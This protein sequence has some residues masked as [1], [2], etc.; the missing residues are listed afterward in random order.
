MATTPMAGMAAPMAY[1]GLQSY[2]QVGGYGGYGA[3]GFGAPAGFG[4]T[5]GF[6]AMAYPAIDVAR[7]EEMKGARVNQIVEQAQALKAQVGH[8]QEHQLALI[9][10]RSDQEIQQ[11]TLQ[12]NARREQ[13][14]LQVSQST[15]QQA[16][17]LDQRQLQA[18][19]QIEQ[20]ALAVS[21]RAHLGFGMAHAGMDVARVE[22]MKGA[23][24]G[25]VMEQ[26]QAMKAQL[27]QVREHQCMMIDTRTDQE[28]QM[29]V[30]QVN[31]RRE[32]AKMQTGLGGQQQLMS[33]EQRQAQSTA[34]L[35][36]Q[37]MAM[38]T[39]ARGPGGAPGGGGV[40]EGS[41]VGDVV[42]GVP[43][44]GCL[45][46]EAVG[47]VRGVGASAACVGPPA[48]GDAECDGELRAAGRRALLIRAM[49][50]LRFPGLVHEP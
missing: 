48:G 40:C 26:A 25:Q 23:Q 41:P 29:L 22:E 8:S 3:A 16:Q 31:Q 38:A 20:Q 44:C 47:W 36:Q 50:E 35:E 4:A 7:V 37:A 18:T 9:D 33:L 17:M 42:E 2:P 14:K 34:A 13:A 1:G 49:R 24:L 39:Q 6:G 28:L 15:Q 12:L 21:S 46:G 11:G 30:A 43:F 10:A 32:Q 45:G 27:T 19:S 5:A